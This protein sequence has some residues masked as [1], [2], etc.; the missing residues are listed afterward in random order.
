MKIVHAVLAL[1]LSCAPAGAAEMI[2][3]VAHIDDGDTF[4]LSSSDRS[5]KIRLCGV[6]SPERGHKNFFS[7]KDALVDLVL[8][9]QVKC[10]KVGDGTP[11]DG[12]S[13]PTNRDRIVA[14]CFVGELDIGREMVRTGHACDWP[15]F[16]A[17]HYKLEPKTCS[18]ND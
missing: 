8:R 15:R 3:V 5:I 13:K 12:R 9:K 4:T 6:D 14:Q 7:A 2:G 17:G 16:S 10:V 11:C 18:R 1:A